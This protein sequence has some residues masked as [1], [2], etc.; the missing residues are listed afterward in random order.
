MQLSCFHK[1][2]LVWKKRCLIMQ[3]TGKSKDQNKIVYPHK[4]KIIVVTNPIPSI[5][6]LPPLD[7]DSIVTE[8]KHTFIVVHA[9][10]TYFRISQIKSQTTIGRPLGEVLLYSRQK[11]LSLSYFLM[12]PP[13]YQYL[14][15]CTHKK[16]S[17][18]AVKAGEEEISSYYLFLSPFLAHAKISTCNSRY[19]DTSLGVSLS[20]QEQ[21]QTTHYLLWVSPICR[22]EKIKKSIQVNLTGK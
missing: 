21:V 20:Q 3:M 15:A 5:I 11:S 16:I 2:E 4:I 8:E 10:Y 14:I 1:V 22:R 9:N 18:V 7:S 13:G 17:S 19:I 12:H 6:L